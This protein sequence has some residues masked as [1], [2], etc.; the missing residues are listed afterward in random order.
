MK[1]ITTLLKTFWVAATISLSPVKFT[2]AIAQN[3]KQ[4]SEEK[5]FDKD[6]KEYIWKSKNR[7]AKFW[8]NKTRKELWHCVD[9]A[10]ILSEEEDAQIE[11]M[12]KDFY[13]KNNIEVVFVTN[14]HIQKG[15]E[16][17]FAVDYGN[18]RGVGENKHYGN[19]IVIMQNPKDRVLWIWVWDNMQFVTSTYEMKNKVLDAWKPFFRE[20]NTVW[21]IQAMLNKLEKILTKNDKKEMKQDKEN[22][23]IEL[24]E[25]TKENIKDIIWGILY[26]L[27]W[28]I[29]VLW[30]W[31]YAKYKKHEY[32]EL[33]QKY[34][35]LLSKTKI[36]N[37]NINMIMIEIE[38]ILEN[39]PNDQKYQKII[40][41][42]KNEY[43]ELK[44]IV[45]QYD[46][47]YM[48]NKSLGDSWRDFVE[49]NKDIIK[50]NIWYF[51][52]KENLLNRYSDDLTKN[53]NS[54]SNID[55]K[56]KA[57]RNIHIADIMIQNKEAIDLVNTYEKEWFRFENTKAIIQSN[58]DELEKL[59]VQNKE[60]IVFVNIEEMNN[61]LLLFEKMQSIWKKQEEAY[62]RLKLARNIYTNTAVYI[63]DDNIS[64]DIFSNISNKYAELFQ[65]CPKDFISSS[66]D[67]GNAQL[68]HKQ[69]KSFPNKINQIKKDKKLDELI[70]TISVYQENVRYVKNAENDIK[71]MISNQ[72]INKELCNQ[73]WAKIEKITKMEYYN[74]ELEELN[75]KYDKIN[76]TIKNDKND[77]TSLLNQT[78]DLQKKYSDLQEK[79]LQKKVRNQQ[80]SN[81]AS[82][83]DNTYFDTNAYNNSNNGWWL[84]SG[85]SARWDWWWTFSVWWGWGTTY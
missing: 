22:A 4:T 72:K 58:N 79:D 52:Q 35:N 80:R 20:W 25:E 63:E 17:Q 41:Q 24:S 32:D 26:V 45:K 36:R 2:S 5:K 81:N 13:D 74:D 31:M 15:H 1:N 46:I 65:I 59:Q 78:K 70:D 33:V 27:V 73:V 29:T 16:E 23:K 67:L 75:K 7:N 42:T 43:N 77:R 12:L 10:W 6:T 76:I 82:R 66:F 60:D 61:F 57:I 68:A 64:D 51:A 50:K 28:I 83:T 18:A 8:Q 44:K 34:N 38:E 54:L 49:S 71:K 19:G 11:S 3:L 69:V 21:A 14:Q 37:V 85:S 55:L 40:N 53:K 62:G 30:G 39:L 47:L 9:G 84:D 56:T 48:D